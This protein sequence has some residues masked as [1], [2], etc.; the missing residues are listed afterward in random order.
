MTGLSAGARRVREG[1]YTLLDGATVQVLLSV[2]WLVASLPVITLPAATVALFVLVA[3][4]RAGTEGPLLRGFLA[5]FQTE[6]RR[7]TLPGLLWMIIGAVLAVDFMIAG[8]MDAGRRPLLVLLGSLTLLYLWVSTSALPVYAS[9]GSG[10]RQALRRTVALVAA[11][12]LPAAAPVLVTGLIGVTCWI[13]PP[14][15][16][17]APAALAW[18]ITVLA[19]RYSRP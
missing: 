19:E 4:R 1:A 10:W 15:I 2:F 3:R 13:L 14:V 7:S 5:V 16:M 11:R 12:P 17:V 6:L 9:E 8:Q 18:M